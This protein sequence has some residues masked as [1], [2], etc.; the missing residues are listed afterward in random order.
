[1]FPTSSLKYGIFLTADTNMRTTANSMRI[2]V[3]FNNTAYSHFVW[4]YILSKSMFVKMLF[5]LK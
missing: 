5:N 1:M 4:A 3:H 2:I